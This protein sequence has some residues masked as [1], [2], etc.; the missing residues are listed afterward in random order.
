MEHSLAQDLDHVL[1]HTESLWPEASGARFFFTGGTGFVGK[2]LLESLLHGENI[3]PW[4]LVS[5]EKFVRILLVRN[6]TGQVRDEKR[7]VAY[8]VRKMRV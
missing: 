4:A 3:K 7:G 1:T 8:P 2:W 5:P 6:G